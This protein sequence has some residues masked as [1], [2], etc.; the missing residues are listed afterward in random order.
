MLSIGK[1]LMI[2]LKGPKTDN[3]LKFMDN[4]ITERNILFITKFLIEVNAYEKI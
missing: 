4:V 1:M 3:F 2:D